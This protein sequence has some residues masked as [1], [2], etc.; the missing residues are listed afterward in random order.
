MVQGVEYLKIVRKGN[1][2]FMHFNVNYLAEL[3]EL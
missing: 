1:L 3:K 2:K